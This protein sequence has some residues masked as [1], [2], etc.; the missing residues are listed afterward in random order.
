MENDLKQK[1]D[2]YSNLPYTIASDRR[3]DQGTYY[4]VARYIELPYLAMTGDTPEE[5]VRELEI[6]KPEWIES[7]LELGNEIPLPLKSRKYSGKIVLRMS[8]KLHEQ[9]IRLSELKGTSLN[10]FMVKAVAEA[11]GY[12]EPKA[13]AC[14]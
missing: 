14:K 10:S 5:A 12:E 7:S 3:D 8:P 11:D 6:E 4:Y 13:P 9:H 2:Y 1:V